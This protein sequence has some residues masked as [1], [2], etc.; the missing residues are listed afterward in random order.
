M[1]ANE[2]GLIY[3]PVTAT[4]AGGRVNMH[5]AAHTFMASGETSAGAGAATVRIQVSNLENPDHDDVSGDAHGYW[6]T[7]G[8]IALTLGTTI[9]A[10]GFA[11]NAGWRWARV[12][13][14]AISGTGATVN[15]YA[16]HS[17][18]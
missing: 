4:G 15:A 14:Q 1:P 7:A 9:T 11:V 13:V 10:D 2:G 12:W 17:A 16:S 5:G 18:F 6:I 8:E 3:G